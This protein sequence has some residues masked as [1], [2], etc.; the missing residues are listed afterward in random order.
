MMIQDPIFLL[1]FLMG[2]RK[3]FSK[4]YRQFQHALSERFA[5]FDIGH[6]MLVIC[7]VACLVA[8]SVGQSIMICCKGFL[9]F[10]E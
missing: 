8:W 3:N 6:I 2:T 7:L 4:H 5:S 10:A 1:K 9:G